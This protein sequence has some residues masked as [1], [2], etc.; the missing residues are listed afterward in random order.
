MCLLLYSLSSKIASKELK[1]SNRLSRKRMEEALRAGKWYWGNSGR[2]WVEE[3]SRW[4]K[5]A[6][7][8]LREEGSKPRLTHPTE[9]G[10][11]S[12]IWGARHLETIC[13]MTEEWMKELW[14]NLVNE[15]CSTTEKH[16]YISVMYKHT[17]GS[18][19]L[20]SPSHTLQYK[21]KWK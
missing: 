8:T 17:E 11:S 10:R 20:H 16:G 7:Q 9:P 6:C 14:Y 12:G 3:L 2:R 5:L 13:P 21:N 19:R 18:T 15:I 1:W 4:H